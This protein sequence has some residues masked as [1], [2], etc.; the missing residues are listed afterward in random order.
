VANIEPNVVAFFSGFQEALDLEEVASAVS[1]VP[2]P[3][4]D[5]LP[6]EL[7]D[8]RRFEVLTYR[9]KS[10][11]IGRQGR[12]SLMQGTGDR[13]RDVVVFDEHG[14]VREI[15]QCKN[16][17]KPITAPAVKR[18][19][20]KLAIHAAIEPKI[21]GAGPVRYEL[22]APGGFTEPAAS[23]FDG[24]PGTWSPSEVKAEAEA[25]LAGVAAFASVTWTAVEQ[26]VC[27]NFARIVE[28]ARMPNEAL[29]PRV[30]ACPPVHRAYFQATSV[31]EKGEVE[32]SLRKLLAEAGFREL[33]DRDAKY[34]MERIQA[35]P[36]DRRHVHGNGYVMGLPP[37]FISHLNQDEY[38]EFAKQAI[39]STFGIVNVVIRAGSRLALESARKFREDVN[40]TQPA[41]IHLVSKTFN[42]SM[43]AQVVGIQYKRM[44]AQPGLAA[45]ELLAL[46]ER[47]A[48]HIEEIWEDL[49][50]CVERYDP[51]ANQP[52]SDEEV[53]FRI[54]QH[55]LR[56]MTSLGAFQQA[57]EAGVDEHISELNQRFQAFMALIPNDLLVVTD[58]K[59]FM[60]NDWILK[61]MVEST[62]V[63]A[64]FRGSPIIP[65]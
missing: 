65:K 32:D 25:L 1:P 28:A 24:W 42:T 46:R 53:R 64:N 45:Y 39:Q 48:S 10:S 37:E 49:R 9:L 52:G 7:L 59:S 40:P 18:E 4:V 36:G 12:V 31:M 29:A 6:F 51:E 19:L 11:E 13:G 43:I 26:D 20:L 15:I 23:I 22:W 17:R 55:S 54:G 62:A 41:L 33:A 21:L 50:N 27:L 8:D 3:G 5:R 58:T 61:R 60:D 34:I 30:R 57:V 2:D 44:G 35:F 47:F 63:V 14:R 56:G 16:L 38:G